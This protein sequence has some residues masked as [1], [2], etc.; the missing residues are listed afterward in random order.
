M[1]GTRDGGVAVNESVMEMDELVVITFA[2]SP[3]PMYSA[4][5]PTTCSPRLLA[6]Y[7]QME[8]QY[9]GRTTK[10]AKV[11]WYQTTTNTS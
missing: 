4:W 2:H 1:G 3:P 6:N 8:V 5:L 10:T 7:N 11:L 9:F